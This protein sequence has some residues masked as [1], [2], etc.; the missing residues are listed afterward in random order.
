MRKTVWG[1]LTVPFTLLPMVEVTPAVSAILTWLLSAI[2]VFRSNRSKEGELSGALKM[3]W[4]MSACFLVCGQYAPYWRPRGTRCDRALCTSLSPP[5]QVTKR[6]ILSTD[7]NDNTGYAAFEWWVNLSLMWATHSCIAHPSRASFWTRKLCLPAV[8]STHT[9]RLTRIRLSHTCCPFWLVN[10]NG[11]VYK[12]HFPWH[13]IT[14]AHKRLSKGWKE[15]VG[16]LF[17]FFFNSIYL[18]FKMNLKFVIQKSFTQRNGSYRR[19]T[20]SIL[21]FQMSFYWHFRY[22]SVQA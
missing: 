22:R 20:L 12:A 7:P 10:S 8:Q 21:N 14:E 5:E 17:F 2:R 18:D 9:H 13:Y 4:R 19:T 1:S 3:R 16:Q 11:F 6:C 15:E